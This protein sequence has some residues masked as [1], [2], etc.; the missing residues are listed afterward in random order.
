MTI[1][2][3]EAAKR[4]NMNPQTLRLALQQDKFPF[5]RAIMTT[6]PEDS[7]LDCGRYTYWIDEQLLDKFLKGELR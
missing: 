6:A 7:K 3:E 5:G 2:V 1:L 4:L